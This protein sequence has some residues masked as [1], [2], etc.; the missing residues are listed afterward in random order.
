LFAVQSDPYP[1]CPVPEP[2]SE[3]NP[4]DRLKGNNV[5]K[6]INADLVPI[7]I[8]TE[9]LDF[10]DRNHTEKAAD[11]IANIITTHELG[12]FTTETFPRA[13]RGRKLDMTQFTTKVLAIIGEFHFMHFLLGNDDDLSDNCFIPAGSAHQQ[14][15][16]DMRQQMIALLCRPRE[17]ESRRQMVALQALESTVTSITDVVLSR[18]SLK[19]LD[20][21]CTELGLGNDPVIFR[22]MRTKPRKNSILGRGQHPA[23][24]A[25]WWIVGEMLLHLFQL[26]LSHG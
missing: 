4:F 2:T 14:H 24:V 17:I 3:T 15:H 7:M 1:G 22:L 9:G 11:Y 20:D 10:Y 6:I 12:G 5:M 19:F 23:E 18:A 16:K 8:A 26:T 21:Y 25:M 13:L